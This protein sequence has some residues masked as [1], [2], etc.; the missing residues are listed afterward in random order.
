M[1]GQF[2]LPPLEE[3]PARE[4]IGN[5]NG[6]FRVRPPGDERLKLA[7]FLFDQHDR[8]LRVGDPLQSAQVVEVIGPTQPLFARGVVF[9]SRVELGR[10][11]RR[12]FVQFVQQLSFAG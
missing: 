7:V 6:Q 4:W 1:V 10:L 8:P 11:I 9:E 3:R 2:V 12:M 5:D